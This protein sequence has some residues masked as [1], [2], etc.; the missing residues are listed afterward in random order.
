MYKFPFDVIVRSANCDFKSAKPVLLGEDN[1]AEK[2][3]DNGSRIYKKKRIRIRLTM[4]WLKHTCNS[5]DF[6]MEDTVI[7]VHQF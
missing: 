2:I 7:I 4:Q 6:V 3:I 1:K 5:I